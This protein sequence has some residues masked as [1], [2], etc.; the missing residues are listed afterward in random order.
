MWVY[1]IKVLCPRPR[2]E[3]PGLPVSA[4]S[5][6]AAK[7]GGDFKGARAESAGE[8]WV[9]GLG[10]SGEWHVSPWPLPTNPPRQLHPGLGFPPGPQ[11]KPPDLLPIFIC[12]Q[13][14]TARQEAVGGVFMD[15]CPPA[16]YMIKKNQARS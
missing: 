7:E 4:V 9:A 8:Q 6:A 12:G 2:S 1:F 3:S 10:S 5:P 15:G 14:A 13:Y 11:P 16:T